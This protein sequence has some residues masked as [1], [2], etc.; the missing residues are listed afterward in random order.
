ML[1]RLFWQGALLVQLHAGMCQDVSS[2]NDWSSWVL[3][4]AGRQL[5]PRFALWHECGSALHYKLI[6]GVQRRC[7][8]IKQDGRSI[9]PEIA[10]LGCG[11]KCISDP[12]VASSMIG[13]C[14]ML[15]VGMLAA[16]VR[17]LSTHRLS[18]A[19]QDNGLRK[20]KVMLLRLHSC[21]HSQRAC[22]GSMCTAA[23]SWP[24]TPMAASRSC[25]ACNAP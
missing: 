1:V 6:I 15:E 20:V 21:C 5:P 24:G 10:Q 9:S 13:L 16:Y 19:C 8:V 23:S 2:R 17:R 22:C 18:N 7:S 14:R 3:Q 12:R 11:H 25:F 4:H